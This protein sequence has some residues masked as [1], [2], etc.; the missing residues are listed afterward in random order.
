[1]PFIKF[2][3][4]IKNNQN[5]KFYSINLIKVKKDIANYENYIKTKIN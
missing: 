5:K 1:M 3:K 2:I 4:N